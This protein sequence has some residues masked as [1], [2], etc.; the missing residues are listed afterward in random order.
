MRLPRPDARN[1][2]VTHHA[3]DRLRECAPWA[4]LADALSAVGSADLVDPGVAAA[5]T[6]RNRPDPG[7]TYLL[8]SER[9]GLFVV[10]PSDRPQGRLWVAV[11]FLRF[12]AHQQALARD[13]YSLAAK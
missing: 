5:F 7:S 10:V 11:T 13:L 1:T 8:E 9:R 4:D 3:L 2:F 6:G 12:G